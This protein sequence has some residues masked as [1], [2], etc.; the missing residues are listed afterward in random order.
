MGMFSYEKKGKQLLSDEDAAK[1]IIA[2]CKFYD[3]DLDE[4]A[5]KVNDSNNNKTKLTGDDI[6]KPVW[7]LVKKGI[8]DI[9]VDGKSIKITQKLV[10]PQGDIKDVVY[11]GLNGRSRRAMGA[12]EDEGTTARVHELLG[13][14]SDFTPKWF[15]NLEG[16]DSVN[17]EKVGAL[18]LAVGN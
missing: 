13:G 16:L 6:G 5:D 7:D 1:Q 10:N 17:V 11:T 2:F 15:G 9:V 3:L 12:A 8:V 18:F 14:M 4:F